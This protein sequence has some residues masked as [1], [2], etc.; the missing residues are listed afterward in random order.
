L[1]DD[2]K[3]PRFYK[4]TLILILFNVADFRSVL[5]SRLSIFFSNKSY[6]SSGKTNF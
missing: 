1:V 6:N 2:V 3:L 4:T 5:G